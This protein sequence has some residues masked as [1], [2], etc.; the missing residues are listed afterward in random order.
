MGGNLRGRAVS[1]A[2]GRFV[3]TGIPPGSYLVSARA[4]AHAP[5]PPAPLTVPPPGSGPLELKFT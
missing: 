3:L 1:R 2:D 4:A 5:L